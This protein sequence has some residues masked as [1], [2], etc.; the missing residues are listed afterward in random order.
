MIEVPDSP[1][2]GHRGSMHG[3][4]CWEA[5]LASVLSSQEPC[6]EH[7]LAGSFPCPLPEVPV[8]CPGGNRS[9]LLRIPSLVR[10]NG[11]S[12]CQP[13]SARVT[14][15]RAKGKMKPGVETGLR[16]VCRLNV[17]GGHQAGLLLGLDDSRTM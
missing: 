5:G 1:W 17:Q 8:C 12:P 3:A 13:V 9:K 15:G 16:A 6:A 11:P 2:G 7:G 10:L 4:G 14:C